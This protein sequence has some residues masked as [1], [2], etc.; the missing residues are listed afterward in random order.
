[1]CVCV[2]R[3]AVIVVATAV[4]CFHESAASYL[5]KRAFRTT[6]ANAEPSHLMHSCRGDEEILWSIFG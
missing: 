5:I 1:M 2:G 6:H 4:D 3:D